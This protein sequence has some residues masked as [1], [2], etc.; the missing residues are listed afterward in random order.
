MHFQRTFGFPKTIGNQLAENMF[1]WQHDF[2]N[3]NDFF[4]RN[5]SNIVDYTYSELPLDKI[6]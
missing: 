1:F 5:G 3:Q 2:E 6:W 4:G